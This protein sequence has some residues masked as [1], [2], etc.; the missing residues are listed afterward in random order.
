MKRLK[1]IIVFLFV[2]VFGFG[3]T[4][5]AEVTFSEKAMETNKAPIEKKSD[6]STEAKRT[7]YMRFGLTSGTKSGTTTDYSFTQTNSSSTYYTLIRSSFYKNVNG[8]M[9]HYKNVEQQIAKDG[10]YNYTDIET[11]FYDA[12][13]CKTTGASMFNC[14]VTDREGS[15]DYP[16]ISTDTF[17][18]NLTKLKYT[19]TYKNAA[20]I[21]NFSQRTYYNAANKPTS[22]YKQ[23]VNA[24]NVITAESS[25]SRTYHSNGK[26]K[27]IYFI[28]R[29]L[30]G[31][32]MVYNGGYRKTYDTRQRM[33]GYAV[34]AKTYYYTHE[35][36][37][38]YYSN[39]KLKAR[40]YIKSNTKGVKLKGYYKTYYSNGKSK[41][42]KK[43]S[44]KKGKPSKMY[45]YKYN[46]K[47]QLKSNKYGKAYRYTTTIKSNGYTIKKVVRAQYNKKG[48]LYGAKRVKATKATRTF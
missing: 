16:R 41:T 3:I 11:Y 14:V 47:G 17:Q 8:K 48:K 15:L 6:N 44:Y 30:S 18:N 22:I 13:K 40:K 7:G 33:T 1:K 37:R 42:Y 5:N 34:I 31:S 24:S 20:N 35:E 43:L 10:S 27:S 12:T 36:Y 39:N 28:R 46:K 45:Y 23:T 19:T 38:T 4:V 32:S 9:F 26:L 21:T 29:Y 2:A 25:D